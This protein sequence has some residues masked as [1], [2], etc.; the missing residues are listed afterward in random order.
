MASQAIK[1]IIVDACDR[2]ELDVHEVLGKITKDDRLFVL[3]S[4]NYRTTLLSEANPI[5]L[6]CK[7]KLD[8]FFECKTKVD[9][10]MDTDLTLVCAHNFADFW[11]TACSMLL[12]SAYQWKIWTSSDI[13]AK[14]DENYLPD[15]EKFVRSYTK[16]G[17][18]EILRSNIISEK[19]IHGFSTRK[20]GL[21]TVP[22]VASLN[23]VHTSAKRDS[24]LIGKENIRRLA[25]SAGFDPEGFVRAKA[26]HGNTVYVIGKTEP[27]DGYDGVV[28]NRN[29]VTVAAPGA[30]CCIMLFADEEGNS[31]GAC[32]S[33]WKGT[34][35]RVCIEIIKKME[36]EFNSKKEN[37]R[38]VFGPSIGICCL[39]FGEKEAELF[40]PI[41]EECVVKKEGKPKP[42]IDLHLANRTLLESYGILPS[43]IDDT[44]VKFCTS[45]NPDLFFS[46]R[47]DG[48]PFGNQVGFIGF[49]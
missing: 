20:G 31:F 15:I 8:G 11:F 23:M 5:Y 24:E 12:T 40:K 16:S 36:E 35:A 37:I 22:G 7:S 21:S 39:E 28:S 19:F 27:E 41:S 34:L 42:F 18:V 1:T 48:K 29:G 33:G 32:H 26:V 25:E 47:R 17:G 9:G 46:Y 10:K 49:K 6:E 4:E 13:H 45:C 2:H 44:S 38:V 3:K 30:D 14:L 43:N